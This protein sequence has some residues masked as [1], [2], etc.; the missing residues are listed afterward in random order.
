MR[1]LISVVLLAAVI[2][3]GSQTAFADVAETPGITNP[4]P[5]PSGTACNTT[6]G[7]TDETTGAVET[8]GLIEFIDVIINTLP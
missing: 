5:P 6:D 1:R 8:P 4:P 2:G 3:I 7:S